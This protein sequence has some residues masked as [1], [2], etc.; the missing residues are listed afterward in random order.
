MSSGGDS[1][2]GLARSPRRPNPPLS[3]A[4]SAL[5]PR[6]LSR[7]PG[8]DDDPQP[9]DG[10][11][12]H[13]EVLMETIRCTVFAAALSL[14]AGL[15]M[16]APA[17][18]AVEMSFDFEY[19]QLS[20]H[21]SWYVSAQYGRVWQPA[22]YAPDWNPYYD[23]HWEYTDLGW[24]WVSDYEWGAVPYHYGTWVLDARYGWVWVPG[25]TW[26]P[27]WVVFRTGDRYCGWAPVP[28]GWTVGASV[29]PDPSLFVFVSTR[30]FLAPRVRGAAI[31][32][33]QAT[34][35]VRDTTVLNSLTIQDNV[36]VNRGPDVRVVERETGRRV[37]PTPIER[38]AR[39]A[40]FERVSRDRLRISSADAARRGVRAA[41][42]VAA[43]RPLPS[44]RGHASERPIARELERGHK[45]VATAPRESAAR[46]RPSGGVADRRHPEQGR[47]AGVG[48]SASR[49][50]VAQ[51]AQRARAEQRR[52]AT[53]SAGQREGGGRQEAKAQ[54]R[55][56]QDTA[57]KAQPR[58]DR[59]AL[60]RTDARAKD[61]QHE[62]QKK[63]EPKKQQE[64]P[65]R[66]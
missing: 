65:D 42:P 29:E 32:R 14:S 31:P 54:T 2:R 51:T 64:Q 43:S 44:E 66:R 34:A 22:V 61:R 8:G 9:P 25:N 41:D 12:L 11:S 26:A 3:R 48:T 24:A 36:V 63:D 58:A 16:P 1:R 38:V 7:S 53:S 5:A 37:Q 15:T 30:D 28:P 21:G 45:S 52:R 13:A 49:G 60:G 46:A 6:L 4:F 10:E 47:S 27:A 57:A 18:A 20:S 23:G 40:P 50:Q 56:R 35:I 55:G 62:P 33:V 19:G 39:I 17:R 59:K